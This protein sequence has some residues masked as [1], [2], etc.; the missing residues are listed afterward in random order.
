MATET[1]THGDYTV[2]WICA[3]SIE[4]RAAMAMLDEL[5]EPLPTPEYDRNIYTLGSIGKH[6]VVI[7]CPPMGTAAPY[8]I[9]MTNIFRA[10]NFS[11]LV[12]VGSGIPPDVRLGDVVVGTLEGHNPKE[13]MLN[14]L[15]EAE[16][17]VHV[18]TWAA[19]PPQPLLEALKKIKTEYEL[20]G[21]RIPEYLERLKRD[22]P[23]LASRYLKSDSLQDLLFDADYGHVTPDFANLSFIP[24][25][26]NDCRFCDKTM[27]VKR[28]PREMRVHY[29]LIASADREI[30]SA[31]LRDRLCRNFGGK[32]LCIDMDIARIKIL[33]PSHYPCLVVRGICDY[34]D[35]HKNMEWRDHAAIMAAAYAKDLLQYVFIEHADR[36]PNVKR[37]TG[38]TIDYQA[39]PTQQPLAPAVL[40]TAYEYIFQ[41]PRPAP[42]HPGPGSGTTLITHVPQSSSRPIYPSPP[43]PPL[44]PRAPLPL[45]LRP[46][47]PLPPPPRLRLVPLPP[48]LRPQAPLPPPLRPRAPLPPP[49]S[50]PYAP[51]FPP[52]MPFSYNANIEIHAA[53]STDETDDLST[54]LTLLS[55]QDLQILEWL[56]P[57]D[58]GPRHRDFLRRW[59][60]ET[61]LW[62]LDS[63]EYK[64]WLST[65]K[66]T[67]FCP[68]DIGSGKT[69]LTSAVINDV[70]TRFQINPVVGIA[71]IYCDHRHK[72]TQQIDELIAS[73]LKQLT[74]KLFSLPD[75]IRQMYEKHKYGQTRPSLNEILGVLHTI[76]G[77]YSRVFIIVDALDECPTSSGCRQT[78]LKEL[79]NLQ[80]QFGVNCFAT[81]RLDPDIIAQ[82]RTNSISLEIRENA[83]DV[84]L[85]VKRYMEQLPAFTELDQWQQETMLVKVLEHV[86][87][88]FLPAAIFVHLLEE[89]LHSEPSITR[90]VEDMLKPNLELTA[91][92][93]A[94]AEASIQILSELEHN[95]EQDVV[96]E[97][98]TVRNEGAWAT[99]LSSRGQFSDSGY[100]SMPR[101]P[102]KRSEVSKNEA[103]M[104]ESYNMIAESESNNVLEELASTDQVDNMTDDADD[105]TEYSA[106]TSLGDSRIEQLVSQLA[107][108]LIGEVFLDGL[109]DR[110]ME[111]VFSTLQ[112]LLKSFAL[113]IGFNAQSQI[114]RDIM[115]YTHKYSRNIARLLETR[116]SNRDQDRD[117][118]GNRIAPELSQEMTRDWLDNLDN[119]DDLDELEP[120]NVP[121]NQDEEEDLEV[122]HPDQGYEEDGETNA[123]NLSAH[124]DLI[125]ASAAYHWLLVTLRRESLLELKCSKM[126]DIRQTI[127]SSLKA[128]QK[129]SR[130]RPAE[131][132]RT[133]FFINWDPIAFLTEQLYDESPEE[134]I[135]KVITLT[136]SAKNAQALTTVQY[137]R[138]TWPTTGEHVL[139]LVKNVLRG[140]SW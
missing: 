37:V 62:L 38:Q 55:E 29:G 75:C 101:D 16:N 109:D 104:E 103:I 60:P 136:G 131:A 135:D 115:Y 112:D 95:S 54:K 64:T 44:R 77:E 106:A 134:A 28:K 127:L 118:S 79:S 125:S 132:F 15:V 68:G 116:L 61:G 128:N 96:T 7:A 113:K 138:Q 36:R 35:S 78:F 111:T 19:T 66:Q 18:E 91:E 92:G 69:I 63:A 120:Y 42:Q 13:M 99:D 97:S 124:R 56:T 39:P 87:K 43:T 8:I 59:Q 34:A 72:E 122:D 2:G 52:W 4:R 26:E 108:Q 117:Q 98:S 102:T 67:L 93:E 107:D 57:V 84:Q 130:S 133:T 65:K 89:K 76:I 82:F 90:A 121:D 83:K 71:Y 119:L 20:S 123:F 5:H 126:E 21:S 70:K 81:S 105:R 100:A 17:S 47:A 88:S 110:S 137:L 46:R 41:N 85:Y 58:Y 10:I 50:Q 9:S 45:S 33:F 32:V 74:Q 129:I 73:I 139:Q 53:I 27:T 30:K 14:P 80:N 6:N 25:E 11:L 114:T 23:A 140:G 86:D 31:P 94:G 3:S 49:L 24:R 1:R 51:D 40:Q 12:G 48:P 22:S